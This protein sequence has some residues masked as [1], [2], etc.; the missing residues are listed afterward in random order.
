MSGF[1]R[2][3][4]KEVWCVCTD[5]CVYVGAC[6]LLH[7]RVCVCVCIL[8]SDASCKIC[9]I[10]I[11]QWNW[12]YNHMIEKQTS[13]PYSPSSSQSFISHFCFLLLQVF[14]TRC[15]S[16]HCTRNRCCTLPSVDPDHHVVCIFNINIIEW[17][18]SCIKGLKVSRM[19][20]H[21]WTVVQHNVS[22]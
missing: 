10:S 15:I 18:S 7:E 11:M 8:T 4:L 20:H 17:F 3:K 19:Q 16:S 2:Q 5:E 9:L 21:L 12:T 6:I 13:S 22:S 1:S 14:P